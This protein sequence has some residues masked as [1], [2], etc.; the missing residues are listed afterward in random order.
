MTKLQRTGRS[1]RVALLFAVAGG[2]C[3]LIA[4]VDRGD[5]GA[6]GVGG[7]AGL[8]G[9]VVG[10]GGTSTGSG[11]TDMV[12]GSTDDSSMVVDMDANPG[13][14]GSAGTGGSSG[15]GGGGEPNDSGATTADVTDGGSGGT[16]NAPDSSV[17]GG[18]LPSGWSLAIYG[19]TSGACPATYT[20]HA[21]IGQTTTP[22]GTCT[23]TC[24]VAQPGS[25][26]QGTLMASVSPGQGNDACVSPWLAVT[27]NSACTLVTANDF[28]HVQIAPLASPSGGSCTSASHLDTALVTKPAQRYCD[29]STANASA[30]CGGVAPAGFSACIVASGNLTCPLSTPF[31]R[32]F[33]LQDD[34]T[35]TCATCTQCSV[36]T[37]CSNPTVSLYGDTTCAGT[38]LGVVA[39]NNTCVG[40]NPGEATVNS[41]AYSATEASACNFGTSTPIV[42]P[43][44]QRTICCQ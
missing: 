15:A 27:V 21:L 33:H 22:A 5:L 39:A 28:D 3:Q 10:V 19:A 13:I 1:A 20:E 41:I 43:V 8:G 24:T 12:D 38:A 9:S 34:A 35:V 26:A 11:G 42:A 37:T 7:S 2:G 30:V 36:T 18:T 31:T 6:T 17:C 40:T 23:C 44:N 32:A 14:G 4:S 16:V 25:C 29:V